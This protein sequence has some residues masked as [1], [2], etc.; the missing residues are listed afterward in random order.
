MDYRAMADALGNWFLDRPMDVTMEADMQCRLVEQLRRE[1]KLN[2]TLM[3][4]CPNPPLTDDGNYAQ[5]KRPYID[6]IAEHSSGTRGRLSRV[7]P[8]VNLSGSD[9]P[10]EQID[11]VVFDRELS[12]PIRWNGGSKRYD[13]RDVTAA[14][15]LKFI[16]NQNVISNDFDTATLRRAS[17]NEMRSDSRIEQL[18]TQNRKLDYDLAR[19]N[20]LPTAE[21]YLII[22]SH[23]NYLFQ[24]ELL[25]GSGATKRKNRKV[26][27]TVDAWLSAEAEQGST[28][29]LYVHPGGKTWWR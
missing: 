23:Y 9:A 7:H 16:K 10:N 6:K 2:D 4:R 14:F 25:D 17:E 15:E 21:T 18:D 19:L 26:G 29:I 13:E 12:Y 3:A 24:P 20:E 22:F 11:V 27:W 5:Y 8:E 28:D 1:L